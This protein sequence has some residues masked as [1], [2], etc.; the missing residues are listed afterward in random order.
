MADKPRVAL[1]VL[2]FDVQGTATDFHSTVQAEATR[3]S[4]GRHG[5]VNWSRFV[6]RWR[7]EYHAALESATRDQGNWTSVCS[8]YRDA[9]DRLLTDY[10]TIGTVPGE[11]A[12]VRHA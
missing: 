4:A 12:V 1:R 9:L 11:W 2:L 6:D 5:D 7:A 10:P 3:I 8:I